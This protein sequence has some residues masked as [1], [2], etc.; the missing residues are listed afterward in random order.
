LLP[1]NL[2]VRNQTKEVGL[3][4]MDHSWHQRPELQQPAPK[5]TEPEPS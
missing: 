4:R 2:V 5:A 1:E 3:F